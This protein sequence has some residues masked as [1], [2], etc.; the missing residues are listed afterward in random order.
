VVDAERRA[1]GV[2]PLT[3]PPVLWTPTE[4]QSEFLAAE[5][6]EVLFGGSAG[7][8]KTDALIVDAL[9]LWQEAPLVPRYKA[10]ILR[11]TYQQLREVIDRTRLLYPNI[12]G[13]GGA[14][15]NASKHEW[16]FPSGAKIIFGYAERDSDVYQFQGEEFTYIALEEL[17][18][19]G[20]AH[21]WDYLRSRLRGTHLKKLMRANC[22]PG[23]IG[24][25]WVQERWQIPDDGRAS[26][27][28]V[29]YDLGDGETATI[30][31]R[32]IP[33]RLS[34]NPYLPSE[35]RA[36]LL[37]MSEMDR[38]A[39]LDGRWDV[40]E[41][42]G[43][44]YKAEVDAAI[45]QGRICSVPHDPSVP[46]HTAW[47]LGIDDAMTIWL[48]QMVG[49]EIH[50]INY[51]EATGEGLVHYFNWLDE[52]ARIHGYRYGED[53]WPHDGRARE[54]GTGKS[55]E[56]IARQ[57]GRKVRIVPRLSV[58]DGIDAMKLLFPRMWFD[59]KLTQRGRECLANYRREWNPGM[60]S[61]KP[62]PVHDWSSHGA[63]AARMLAVGIRER[64]GQVG[65]KKTV[66]RLYGGSGNTAWLGG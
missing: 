27:H 53:L 25:K 19:W 48:Y 57:N 30:R 56:E 15:Y 14:R 34:D 17:T 47:D 62:E 28:S 6:E 12:A 42:P 44:I 40:Q 50:L 11:R 4:R 31:R 63:D 10:L 49:R 51:Y 9:G 16:V 54:L 33:A 24:S 32:F 13:L 35:Y 1:E 29:E 55:R 8:G 38:R 20:T 41:V 36:N 21:V 39:L 58:Q 64:S 26:C 52:Q 66:P 43:A 22:N 65:P 61:Y 45:A 18:Q 2:V 59:E 60:Q 3:T 5:E 7:G 37:S 23:G 46:V